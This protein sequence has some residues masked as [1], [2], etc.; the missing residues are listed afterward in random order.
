M[1]DKTNKHGP[2]LDDQ[3]EHETEG[4]VRGGHPTHA[5]EFKE[6]EP[7]ST[8]AGRDPT[9]GTTPGEEG[10]PPGMTA[11]DVE[12]RAEYARMIVGVRY[13][14]SGREIAEH[15]AAQGAPDGA[16][17]A[18]RNLPNRQYENL[19]DVTGELGIGQENR[20]F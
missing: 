14:A 1:T 3:M 12:E 13:P 6:T 17:A 10:A 20:R 9:A 8:D 5:E 2:R 11:D 15:A 18:L 7:V 4:L 19:A 16:V